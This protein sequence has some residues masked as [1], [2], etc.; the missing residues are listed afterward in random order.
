VG[1][2]TAIAYLT[3][4]QF[5]EWEKHQ[6]DKHEY[7]RGEVYAMAGADRNHV[8]ATLN[9]ATLLLQNRLRGG[10]CRVYMSDMKV[11]VDEADATFYPDVVVT[12]D[13]RDH[14]AALFMSHPKLII[15][16]LSESTE[17]YDRGNKF[18]TYRML[19]SLE[20][21]VLVDIDLPSVE[22]YRR[23]TNDRWVLQ[24]FRGQ[25]EVELASLG[26]RLALTDIFENVG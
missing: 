6:R 26:L 12:C 16:V 9:I 23:A 2:P 18:A 17:R 8:R 11:R 20:E 1:F 5:L 13:E 15:E 10:P 7:V 25:S 21:Y 24:D 3:H 14:R 22:C 4:A 19:G